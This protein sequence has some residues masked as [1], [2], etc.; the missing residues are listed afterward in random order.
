[1]FSVAQP[2]V[3]ASTLGWIQTLAASHYGPRSRGAEGRPH[4]AA[5]RRLGA[6]RRV[7]PWGGTRAA[8]PGIGQLTE[9][10]RLALIDAEPEIEEVAPTMLMAS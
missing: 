6:W 7:T 10:V 9:G 2:R 8:R 1:V 4:P 5:A 3:S